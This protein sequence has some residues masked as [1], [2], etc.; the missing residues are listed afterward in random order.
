MSIWNKI[1]IGLVFL[2][3]LGF[4]YLAA[5]ALKTHQEWRQAAQAFEEK[6]A[7]TKEI[8][9]QLEA[10]DKPTREA[11]GDEIAWGIKR[12][13]LELHKIYL[14]RGR[15]W[16]NCDPQQPDAQSGQVVVN[17]D[18]PDPHGITPKMVLYVFEEGAGQ[19]EPQYLGEFKVTDVAE[20]QVQLEPT[21]EMTQAELQRLSRSGGPWLLYERM[22][23]DRHALFA[24]FEEDQLREMLPESSVM[25][26]VRDGQPATWADV[27]EWDVQGQVVDDEGKPLL[28]AEGQPIEGVQGKF[29]RLLR[30]YE[31]IFQ[32]YVS[33][34]VECV[35]L[36]ES[37]TRDK[38]YSETALADAQKHEQFR[39]NQLKAL[40][41][42]LGVYVRERGA[43][44]AH[45][46]ALQAKVA[47]L[48]QAVEQLLATNEA[49][50]GRIAEIQ[51][52]A[53]RRI[54]ARSPPV[55]AGAGQ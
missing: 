24:G 34:R 44:L 21:M 10:A 43:V 36:I 27:A 13:R 39:R 51:L 6:I 33:R 3:G 12:L 26:Y 49:T 47:A 38:Q 17:T 32:N 18:L 7:E 31:L 20:R 9:R 15:V 50:V 46:R 1:L 2:A 5:R 19:R 52:E 54:D 8:N 40:N 11:D 30:D 25:D 29:Q 48:S 45:E 41:D 23:V 14:D 53:A 4:S 42:K 55:T 37:A 28:D 22:P 16:E 35:D